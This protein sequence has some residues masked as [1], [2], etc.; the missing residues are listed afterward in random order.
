MEIKAVLATSTIPTNGINNPAIVTTTITTTPTIVRARRAIHPFRPRRPTIRIHRRQLAIK[1]A[2]LRRHRLAII[3]I[4][5]T[6]V[7]IIVRRTVAS[8]R[9][10]AVVAVAEV[11]GIPTTVVDP[12]RRLTTTKMAAVAAA[13]ATIKEE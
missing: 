7:Q 12:I 8:R 2:I 6:R 1:L 13:A 11:T 5:I 3:R 9:T 4:L 10:A